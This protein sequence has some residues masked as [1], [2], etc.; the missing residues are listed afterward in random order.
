MTISHTYHFF[1][2][3]LVG[4]NTDKRQGV[5]DDYFLSVTTP[6]RGRVV[7]IRGN[8]AQHFGMYALAFRF[9]IAGCMPSVDAP[10]IV[11]APGIVVLPV[12]KFF[13]KFIIHFKIVITVGFQACLFQSMDSFMRLG[14]NLKSPLQKGYGIFVF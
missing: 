7:K 8:T 10:V 5:C 2:A 3:F 11:G 1:R 9:N 14:I 12:S 13:L 6:A 4:D